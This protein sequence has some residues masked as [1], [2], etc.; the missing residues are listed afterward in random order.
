[1]IKHAHSL[2]LQQM[3]EFIKNRFSKK[4]SILDDLNNLMHQQCHKKFNNYFIFIMK[5][6]IIYVIRGKSWHLELS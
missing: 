4:L 6:M 2:L 1:M 5:M 3:H